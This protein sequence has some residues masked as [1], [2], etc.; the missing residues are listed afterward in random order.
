VEGSIAWVRG[1]F[2]FEEADMR[3]VM[4]QLTRWYDV[5]IV[6]DGNISSEKI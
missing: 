5:E 2:H 6:F 4:C 3:S 1:Y